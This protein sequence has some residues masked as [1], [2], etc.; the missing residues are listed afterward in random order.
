MPD[1][2]VIEG[3]IGRAWIM[4]IEPRTPDQTATLAT[5]IVHAPWAHPI[6]SQYAVTLIHLRDIQGVKPAHKYDPRAT[7]EVQVWALDPEARL[8]P[9]D[10]PKPRMLLTPQNFVGQWNAQD[11]ECA[12][13]HIEN[14]VRAIV[15]GRLSPDTDFRAA[16]KRLF[17]F[18]PYDA[19]PAFQR[20][21]LA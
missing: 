11:D 14:V 21:G 15:N 16:W 7:H 8:R 1:P 9:G 6:W 10:P 5:W 4:P 2:T 19:A 20:A 18:H 13:T 3:A 17:P 12:K